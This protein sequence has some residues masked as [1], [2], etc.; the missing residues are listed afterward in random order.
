MV[1]SLYKAFPF[2]SIEV[3]DNP[4]VMISIKASKILANGFTVV[5]WRLK[6]IVDVNYCKSRLTR[7]ERKS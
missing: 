4:R 7:Q 1:S 6:S 2:S 5:D 3:H